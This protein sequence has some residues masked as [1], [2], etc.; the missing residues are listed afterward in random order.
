ME[1]PGLCV[2]C[3]RVANPAYS[4]RLCGAIVCS[5]HFSKERGVCT[6]CLSGARH[7]HGGID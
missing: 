1:R 3:G 2:I 4:C 6:N 7:S 5:E